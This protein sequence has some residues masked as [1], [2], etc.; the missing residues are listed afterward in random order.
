MIVK[1]FVDVSRT[2]ELLFLPTCGLIMMFFCLCLQQKHAF[3]S[4]ASIFQC[5][6][7]VRSI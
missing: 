3:L 6:L 4:L 5:S 2:V 7:E 1:S